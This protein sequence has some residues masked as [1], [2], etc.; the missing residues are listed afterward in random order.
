MTQEHDEE[1]AADPIDVE[2]STVE[3]D[4]AAKITVEETPEPEVAEVEK[5]MAPVP[6]TPN[7]RPTANITTP[8]LAD[9]GISSHTLA[10][11]GILIQMLV[12]P[13]S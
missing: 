9:F 8:S 5:P 3:E 2:V 1:E 12:P 13:T 7:K 10:L 6:M 4:E 11:L